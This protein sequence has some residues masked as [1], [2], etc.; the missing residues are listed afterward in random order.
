MEYDLGWP[1]PCMYIYTY[2]RCV[3]YVWQGNHQVYGHVRCIYTYIY[4]VLANLRMMLEGKKGKGL[5]KQCKLLPVSKDRR[6][7][8]ILGSS[9][10]QR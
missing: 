2:I 6:G 1:E 5:Q 10:P 9:S 3:Q 4:T 8:A 7:K